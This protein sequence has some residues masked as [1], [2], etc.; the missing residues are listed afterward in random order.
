MITEKTILAVD[1]NIDTL[2]LLDMMLRKHYKILT[3]SNGEDALIL[4]GKE[5]PDLVLLDIVMPVMDGF[6]VC[7][8]LKDN[9]KTQDIPIIFVTGLESEQNRQKCLQLGAV[10]FLSKPYSLD[11][12]RRTID[13]HI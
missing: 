5:T 11:N 1:D 13:N 9:D 6:E 2:H 8:A 12:L 7:K 10:D 4:A 3:A